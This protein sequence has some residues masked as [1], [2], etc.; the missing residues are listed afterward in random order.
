MVFIAYVCSIK[1]DMKSR[2]EN[3]G[4]VVSSWHCAGQ[5]RGNKQMDPWKVL[6]H[7][8]NKETSALGVKKNK[9]SH[10]KITG[11]EKVQHIHKN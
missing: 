11:D 9:C 6:W 2:F 7:G 3:V 5:M 1:S 4:L 10:Q 8:K